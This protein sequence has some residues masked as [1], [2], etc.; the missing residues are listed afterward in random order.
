[1]TSRPNLFSV[2]LEEWFHICGV[3]GSL[4]PSCWDQLPSR[5]E[6]GLPDVGLVPI[7]EIAVRGIAEPVSV[8]SL[9]G[10]DVPAER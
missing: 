1:M 5:V 6:I 4:A 3:D 8:Y 2:D 7:G 9:P 10:S